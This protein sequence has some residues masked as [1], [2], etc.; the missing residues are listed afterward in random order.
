[1]RDVPLGSVAVVG[2]GLAGC[3]AALALARR[4]RRVTLYEMRP[5]R[6][7]PA[8]RTDALGEL[9]CTNSFKSEVPATAHGQLKR[10][11]RRLGSALL[12]AAEES[13]GARRSAALAVDRRLFAEALTEACA[14]PS[15]HHRSCGRS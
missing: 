9:V 8:H 1:M 10:E 6:T 15:R 4:D 5:K 13:Q 11:M 3:E 14:V 7:T 2:G 12:A